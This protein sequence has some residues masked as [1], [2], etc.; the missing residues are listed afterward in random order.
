M[1]TSTWWD[2]F[3]A[4]IRGRLISCNS[5]EKKKKEEKMKSLQDKL[6][7]QET[8]LKKKPGKKKLEKEIRLLKEQIRSFD[9]QE[10]L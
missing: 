5:Y 6:I 9:N 4:V 1:K 10:M 8:E 7:W 2:T 3:K